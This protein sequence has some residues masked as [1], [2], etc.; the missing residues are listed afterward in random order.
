MNNCYDYIIIG[1][2]TAG[3]IL[4]RKLS[5]NPQNKVLLIEEGYWLSLNPQVQN[6][7]QWYSIRFDPLIE[8]GYVSTLQAGFGYRSIPIPRAKGTGGTNSMNGMVFII[9]NRKDFDERWGPINGWSW[10]D[11]SSYWKSIQKTISPSPLDPKHPLIQKL[12]KSATENGYKYNRNPNDLDSKQGQGGVS[13][14]IH[15][16]KKISDNYAE[17]MSSWNAYIQP[18]L[19]RKNLDILVFTQVTKILFDKSLRSIGVTTYN[20]GKKEYIYFYSRKEIILS[21]GVFDTPKLLLLSGIGPC[22]EL[23]KHNIK[24]L[25]DVPGVGKNLQDHTFLELHS[26]PLRNQ[27]ISLPKNIFGTWGVIA[28]EE[29]GEYYHGLQIGEINGIY[30]IQIFVETFHYTSRGS[31]TLFDKNPFSK[32]IINPNFLSNSY[33]INKTLHS[34]Q[35]ARKFLLSKSISELIEKFNK[36]NI[37]SFHINDEK[38]LLQWIKENIKSD[39]HPSSTCSMGNN[40]QDNHMIVVNPRL[41]VRHTKQLR[42]ADGSIIPYLISGNPNQITMIIGMKAAEMILEDNN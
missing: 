24:C 38:K 32:P 8:R 1:A 20:I 13:T 40:F 7:S 33:D 12:I 3:S 25:A 41:K 2:G 11:L 36:F 22:N 42:I 30:K 29:N 35:V 21:A 27:N 9:G 15:M 14:R 19:P 28:I 4:A 23:I 39:A 16:A 5:D 37:P 6:A 18:I 17:R 26:T 34:V 31:I 10:N